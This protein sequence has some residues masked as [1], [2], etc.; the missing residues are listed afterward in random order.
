MNVFPHTIY[1]AK[2]LSGQLND[3]FKQY[4][5]CP[6]CHTIY[7][8]EDCWKYENNV[9]VSKK[10]MY[11]EFPNHIQ[12][13]M[14]IPCDHILLK[15]VRATNG[16]T[17]LQPYKTY[18]YQSIVDSFEQLLNRPNFIQTCE[19]WRSRINYDVNV[20]QDVYDGEI[21]KRYEFDDNG[22]PFLSAPYNYLLM[23]NCDWFQPYKHTQ[24]SVGVLYF[25]IQNLPRE[26]RFIRENIIIV[27]IM[28]GPSELKKNINTYLRPMIDELLTLWKGVAIEVNGKQ[29]TIRVAVSCLACDIPAARKVGGFIG[30]RG[31]RG[32]SRCW[33]EFPTIDGKD[34][35][36]YSGFDKQMWEPRSHA[37]HVWYALQ[38]QNSK[39]KDE[40]R[41][42]ESNYGARYSLL[43]DLPYYNAIS[44][45]IVDPM[46]CLY[47]GIAKRFFHI[48]LTNQILSK[49]QLMMIQQKVDAMCCPP[50]IGRI[51]YKIVSNFAGLK[52]DQWKNWTLYFSLFSLKEFVPYRDYNCWLLFVKICSKICRREIAI[53]D[54]DEIDID[55]KNFCVQFESLYGKAALTPNIHLLG[56]ITDC[57]RDHGPVY[58]F[59]L[60]AFERMNGVL[61]SFQTNFHDINVQLMRRFTT[62]QRLT[63]DNWPI[64]MRE[65][66]SSLMEGGDKNVG[67]LGEMM[68][69]DKSSTIIPL[70]PIQE[71]ALDDDEIQEIRTIFESIHPITRIVRLCKSCKAI[72]VSD[73]IV[74][75]MQ[76]SI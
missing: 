49:D 35:P 1:R 13:R 43:Y 56:H 14:R 7:R 15:T 39:T 73:T 19:Q 67:S 28:P 50:D 68:L 2:K 10:C 76:V 40:R 12:S 25:A 54:L 66:F 9:K 17:Y 65:H 51:P 48:W 4:V 46:H 22:A 5:S 37:L 74:S 36:D 59:W 16:S 20:M 8:F 57:I 23:L 27:G 71:I 30:H 33:K 11:V 58:A 47:L 63:I 24:F 45:C 38:Q 18:C 3:S 64:D 31:K 60:Y 69:S 42:K 75:F 6:K 70:P 26:L 21:W 61:G 32:C 34:Y 62:M 72:A 29:I 41:E 53:P 52:A 44:S 55:I